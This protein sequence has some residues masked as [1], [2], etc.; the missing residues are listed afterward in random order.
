MHGGKTPRGVELPQFRHGHYSKAMPDRL[1]E[2]Y[3]RALSDEERYDL[4]DEIALSEA[5]IA[6]LL[7]GMESG[8]SEDALRSRWREVERW[9]ARKQRAVETDARLAVIKQE[10]VSAEEVMALVAG[11]LDSIRRHVVDQTTRS[12]LARDI[13]ALGWVGGGREEER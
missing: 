12:A 11:I 2:R 4:R 3:E 6:D 5:K 9:I 1:V 10:M 13:R 7:A 8:A